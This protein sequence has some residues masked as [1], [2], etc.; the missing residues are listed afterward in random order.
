VCCDSGF[1]FIQPRFIKEENKMLSFSEI[2]VFVASAETG[3]FS[4][5]ARRLHL[6]QPAVSQQI[7]SLER[8]L[9][10]KLFRRTS[11]GVTLTNA[12][13]ALLPMARELL[14]LSH[15][16]RE[17]M[18]SLEARSTAHL[19]VGCTAATGKVVIPLLVAAFNQ[20][21][22][23]TQVTIEMNHCDSVEKALLAQEI[24]LGISGTEAVHQRIECQPFFTDHVILVVPPDHPFAQ[25]P[26]V[27]PGELIGQPFILHDEKCSTRQMVQEELTE[28]GIS[29]DQLQVV[30]IA[31]QA[32]AIRVAVEHK[33]GIAFICRLAA[34]HELRSRH[35]V[36]VPVEG[37][38]LERP[39]Y[40]MH[41][42]RPPMTTAQSHFW[43]FVGTH[44]DNIAQML[45]V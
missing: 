38:R 42:T 23:D 43:N 37:L 8:Y 34:R 13:K 39:L 12:G 1:R 45:R 25:R 4:K 19:T 3:S 31:E 11:R 20:D 27:Q 26:S 24:H 44:K 35:L 28:Q 15:R 2:Q 21:H 16:I 14:S 5:A 29:L 6:S 10:T 40:L 30:M 32:E 17:T 7:R 36:K 9:R 22:Q 18:D 41:D 33:L